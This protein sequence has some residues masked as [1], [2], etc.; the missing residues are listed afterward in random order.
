MSGS[1]R[2]SEVRLRGEK[3]GENAIRIYDVK[4]K[5]IFNKRKNSTYKVI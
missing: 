4:K 2:E 3:E 1:G 5:P